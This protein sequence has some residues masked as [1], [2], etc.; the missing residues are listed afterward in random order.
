L[1]NLTK[2]RRQIGDDVYVD[3]M[4]NYETYK[5][6]VKEYLPLEVEDFRWLSI[7]LMLCGRARVNSKRV[8]G[9]D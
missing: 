4:V 7:Q 2:L 1:N 3:K 6:K 8:S 9:I 5:L